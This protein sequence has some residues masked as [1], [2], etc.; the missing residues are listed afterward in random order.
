MIYPFKVMV[1]AY[2]EEETALEISCEIAR[3]LYTKLNYVSCIRR[4][5]NKMF[6]MK[7]VLWALFL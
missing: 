5:R 4:V 6:G 1:M 3:I 2:F 7:S